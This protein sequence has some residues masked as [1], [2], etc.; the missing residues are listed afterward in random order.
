[1]PTIHPT[2]SSDVVFISPSI[3]GVTKDWFAPEYWQTQEKLLNTATG[4]GTVWFLD[5][6]HG[7]AVL[8]QYRRGGLIAKFNKFSFLTQPFEQTRPFKELALLEQL[9]KLDLPAPQPIAGMV[10]REGLFYQ[11]WLLTK[12]IP[13]A[14]DLFEVLQQKHLSSEMW[15]KIG[16]TIKR[17]H[18]QNVFHS[19]LN[20][21]N[22]MIDDQENVWI[23]DFDKCSFK[24]DLAGW[25]KA[26]LSRLQ[27]SFEKELS[28]VSSFEY[29]KQAWQ[30]LMSGYNSL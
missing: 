5:T 16:Q 17:F 6:P 3:K 7:E 10:R 27:R 12:V 23:I 4:R 20:C 8:R 22:I 21:H 29:D 14:K 19:D 30:E 9:Q 13:N 18:V 28:K 2:A 25:K 24:M 11:A 1:M 26:N 15:Q